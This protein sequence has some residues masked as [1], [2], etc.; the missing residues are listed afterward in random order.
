M[1]LERPRITWMEFFAMSIGAIG[2]TIAVAAIAT[3]ISAWMGWQ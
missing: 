1:H 3:G 2:I